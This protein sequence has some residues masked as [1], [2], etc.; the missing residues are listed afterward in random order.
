MVSLNGDVI[1]NVQYKADVCLPVIGTVIK[2]VI[3]N[4]NKFGI[5]AEASI[6]GVD[7]YGKLTK[8]SVIEVIITKHAVGITNTVELES[9]VVGDEINVEIMGKKFELNDKKICAIGRVVSDEVRKPNELTKEEEILEGGEDDGDTTC[10]S[11]AD[12]EDCAE[13]DDDENEN[14]E[15]DDEDEECVEI[16]EDCEDELDTFDD[17]DSEPG[18]SDPESA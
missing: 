10:S 6:S 15:E 14:N 2:A 5:L 11:V 17:C 9:L 8:I 16:E 7:E 3:T 13:E 1:Y 4:I 12:S 18:C